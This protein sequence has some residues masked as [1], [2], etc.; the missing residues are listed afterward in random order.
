M[1]RISTRGL[2]LLIL[3][4][5]C[6]A[7]AQQ[8]NY[9][10]QNVDYRTLDTLTET[11]HIAMNYTVASALLNMTQTD[12]V[13]LDHGSIQGMPFYLLVKPTA[14]KTLHFDSSIVGDS[15]AVDSGK[16]YY[17][18]FVFFDTLWYLN[19]VSSNGWSSGGGG[20]GTVTSVALSGGS[21]GLTYSGSPITTSGTI[22]TAGILNA[23]SGGTGFGHYTTGNMLYA[24]SANR[25]DTLSIGTSGQVLEVSSGVPHWTTATG[26]TATGTIDFS[27]PADQLV[28]DTLIAS[29]PLIV[30]TSKPTVP[31][32]YYVVQAS[33]IPTNTYVSHYMAVLTLGG[34]NRNTAAAVTVDWVGARGTNPATEF[35]SPSSISTPSL[36]YWRV[37]YWYN[38]KDVSV[39]DTLSVKLWAS[40][41][42][43]VDFRYATIYFIPRLITPPNGEFYFY[44]QANNSTSV[45]WDFSTVLTGA[46]SGVA[47]SA[48]A[49]QPTAFLIDSAL[50]VAGTILQPILTNANSFPMFIF[51]NGQY[52]G[53]GQSSILGDIDNT[54]A[55]AVSATLYSLPAS[56]GTARR[57][58][59][60]RYWSIGIH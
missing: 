45:P 2:I 25:L 33:D 41:T 16:V 14:T 50:G 10:W 38:S 36:N 32:F 24:D 49:N 18:S 51:G 3:L 46:N 19:S 44:G 37:I 21:T 13:G 15:I 40:T 22:T 47:Y 12:T 57:I 52:V 34:K 31:Q 17:L 56:N 26:T 5:P 7:F 35:T 59:Y 60:M 54:S 55:T 42:D 11:T 43:T 27:S 48:Y 8:T 30:P 58:R 6:F 20:S 39:G 53:F 4:L 23:T 9:T 28:K 1:G 29:N